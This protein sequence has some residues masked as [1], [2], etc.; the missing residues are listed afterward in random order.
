MYVVCNYFF[1]NF[2]RIFFSYSK[3]YPSTKNS[4]RQKIKKKKKNSRNVNVIRVPKVIPTCMPL[5][6][7]RLSVRNCFPYLLCLFKIIFWK[8]ILNS[9][10]NGDSCWIKVQKFVYLLKKSLFS[11]NLWP[12]GFINFKYQLSRCNKRKYV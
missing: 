10:L 1:V 12:S 4:C 2:F 9:N 5:P 11:V 8:F 7:I 3:L 6:S